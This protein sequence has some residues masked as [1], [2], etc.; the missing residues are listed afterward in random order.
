LPYLQLKEL[1]MHARFA[2]SSLLALAGGF[3]VVASQSFTSGVTAWLAFAIGILAVVLAAVPALFGARRWVLGLD[4]ATGVLGAW[5]IVASLVFSG[6]AV[7]WLSFAEGA[8]F[9]ALALAGLVVDHV[10][11][12]QRAGVVA[13][14]RDATVTNVERPTTIAA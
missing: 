12:S 3:L 6:G 7:R 2:Q 13:S 5:T 10:S 14:R 9:V 11:L 8:G 1:I 4:A